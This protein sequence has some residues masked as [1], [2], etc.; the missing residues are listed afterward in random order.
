MGEQRPLPGALPRRNEEPDVQ[1][2]DILDVH[3]QRDRAQ[4]H[5]LLHLLVHHGLLATADGQSL[6]LAGTGIT[7]YTAVLFTVTAKIS[8]ESHQWTIPNLVVNVGSIGMWFFFL[9][10]YGNMFSTSKI[11]SF[12]WWYGLPVLA[13]GHPVY[14]FVVMLCV[15]VC[16]LR[17]IAW[18]C[19]R[20]NFAQKLVHIVQEFSHE[21]KRFTRRDVAR[22]AP[23]LLPK[24]DALKPYDVAGVSRR[25]NDNE[26]SMAALIGIGGNSPRRRVTAG[27]ESDNRR[28]GDTKDAKADRPPTGA[29]FSKP[30]S[31]NIKSI[32]LNYD[33]L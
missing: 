18:K 6:G 12:A 31:T 22:C 2:H 11:S 29:F 4:P 19:W 21:G 33:D 8:F 5:L 28:R 17:E 9:G 10:I 26:I 20:H 16:M 27:V 15:A 7:C 13:L 3:V 32:I 23:H 30:G 24:F 25:D 1:H 14:W